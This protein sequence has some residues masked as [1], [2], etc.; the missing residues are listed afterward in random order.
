M[1]IILDQNS[2]LKCCDD[3]AI[4]PKKVF[5]F[6]PINEIANYSNNTLID[7]IGVVVH[8]GKVSIVQIMDQ[9]KMIL[10]T[11]KLND[12][13]S[14]Y[15]DVNLWGPNWEAKGDD[16]ERLCTPT[17]IVILVVRNGHV[18]YFNGSILNTFVGTALYI[19]LDIL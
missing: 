12:L 10:R 1:E 3:E 19:N 7:I 13:S 4:V 6:S 15:I 16:L 5:K 11:M 14:S 17:T 8:V 9:T 2:I 18:G